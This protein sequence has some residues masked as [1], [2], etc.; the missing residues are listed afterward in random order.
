MVVVGG[1]KRG[2]IMEEE[3]IEHLYCS[4]SD[5]KKQLTIVNQ[6]EIETETHFDISRS[7]KE[8]EVNADNELIEQG[9]NE[10]MNRVLCEPCFLKA[11]NES[12]T[13]G[14]LFIDKEKNKFIY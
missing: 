7:N 3:E 12:P 11:C 6:G 14:N 5:C 9:R 1:I 13:I 2:G 10:K 8:F 4:N